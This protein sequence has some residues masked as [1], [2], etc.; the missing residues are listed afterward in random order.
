M[1]VNEPR[2]GE[3]FL[4]DF[5]AILGVGRDVDQQTIA[6]AYHKKAMEWH[7]DPHERLAA[8]IKHQMNE[9]MSVINLAKETLLDPQ[10]RKEYDEQLAGW[11]GPI[12]TTGM[13]TISLDS[14]NL[15]SI[16]LLA[17]AIE[18][19]DYAKE[20]R[21]LAAQFSGHDQKVFDLV[22]SLYKQALEPSA[23]LADAY[24][25]VL[26]KQDVY[27]E[28]QSQI[29]W[30][31]IGYHG[32]PIE[33]QMFPDYTDTTEAELKEVRA[34]IVADGGEKLA[35]IQRGELKA[36]GPGGEKVS[37]ALATNPDKTTTQYQEIIGKRFDIGAERVRELARERQALIN[38]RLEVLDCTY[39]SEQQEIFPRVLIRVEIGEN[40]VWFA[41][42]L[43]P[44]SKIETDDSIDETVL[45]AIEDSQ[46]EM[47]KWIAKGYSIILFKPE[48]NV[49]I[50]E[51]LRAVL[52]NHFEKLL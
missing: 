41:F 49:K 40:H 7:T 22:Q 48:D 10:K 37:Q 31:A 26:R 3:G 23:E 8:E 14:P 11:K 35:L 20:R 47:R 16:P 24:R 21:A 12:S 25:E 38:E 51:Q 44:E 39:W 42:V 17:G 32:R 36:L 18:D 5:Y 45:A 4:Y 29:A 50:H 30:E 15:S 1:T 27:L 19:P 43:K 46:D 33:R 9:K 52:S 28:L 6:S 13:P 34:K 2:H